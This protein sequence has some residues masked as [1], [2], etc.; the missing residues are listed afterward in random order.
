MFLKAGDLKNVRVSSLLSLMAN[1]GLS[2]L[3]LQTLEQIQWNS[4]DLGVVRVR[5]GTR[6]FCLLLLL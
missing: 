6:R 2:V 5:Q 4:N 3:T 1:T